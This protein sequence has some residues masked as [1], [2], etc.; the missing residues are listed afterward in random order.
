MAT[1]VSQKLVNHVPEG[2]HAWLS[3]TDYRKLR[4]LADAAVGGDDA[5]LAPLQAFLERTAGLS[6]PS[7]I[8]GE[9]LRRAAFTLVR[10]GYR[11]E[12]IDPGE[13]G[14]LLVLFEVAQRADSDDMEL[15]ETGAHRAIYTFLMQRLGLDV[16]AGRGPVWH[17]AAKLLEVYRAAIPDMG[18][19]DIDR[20]HRVG[21]ECAAMCA[22]VLALARAEQRGK[23]AEVLAERG[24]LPHV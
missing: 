10:R 14:W 4:T 12:S 1:D 3:Y 11:V 2:R 22:A 24:S 13:Y 7:D 19:S 15:A 17:R 5:A 21:L 23:V 6:L 16:E 8:D 20:A 18:E 9:A